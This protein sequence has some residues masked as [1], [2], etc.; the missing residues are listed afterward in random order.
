MNSTDDVRADESPRATTGPNARMMTQRNLQCPLVDPNS[1]Q[2]AVVVP[3]D[4]R[5]KAMR[6]AVLVE[7]AG[8]EGFSEVAI[9]VA[10]SGWRRD[11][12]KS[13]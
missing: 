1:A 12:T 11:L 8:F 9:L 4:D 6:W 13:W 5:R 7:T 10:R 2:A 3:G